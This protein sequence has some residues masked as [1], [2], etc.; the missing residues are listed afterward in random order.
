MIDTDHS[1]FIEYDE[2]K[3]FQC[4]LAKLLGTEEPSDEKIRHTM[5]LLD[6]NQDGK[7]SFDEIKNKI[8]ELV[9]IHY[10]KFS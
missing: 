8:Q 3:K 1:G 7:L 9:L 5:Q 2:L 6:K 10:D 4:E